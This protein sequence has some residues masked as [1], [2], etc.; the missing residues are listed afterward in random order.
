MSN[1]YFF[2]TAS[3][4]KIAQANQSL[5][6]LI[7]NLKHTKTKCIA[8]LEISTGICSDSFDFNL[9]VEWEI[10]CFSKQLWKGMR[11]ASTTPSQYI[12]LK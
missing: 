10:L 6:N 2:I 9:F 11:W 8:Q 3:Y 7:V 12:T 1:I 5:V 4:L